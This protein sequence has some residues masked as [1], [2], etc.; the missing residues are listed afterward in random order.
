MQELDQLFLVVHAAWFSFNSTQ[1][2]SWLVRIEMSSVPTIRGSLLLFLYTVTVPLNQY[3]IYS[4][5]YDLLL[6][7]AKTLLFSLFAISR[8]WIQYAITT[9]NDATIN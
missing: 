8:P 6:A 3:A 1:L 9:G 5:L 4:Y 7:N 2:V